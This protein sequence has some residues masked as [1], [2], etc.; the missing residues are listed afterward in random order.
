MYIDV[1]STLI[2]LFLTLPAKCITTCSTGMR[3]TICMCAKY[4]HLETMADKGINDQEDEIVRDF[5]LNSDSGTM[6]LSNK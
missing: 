3:I 2:G 1:K 6:N 5:F 4:L